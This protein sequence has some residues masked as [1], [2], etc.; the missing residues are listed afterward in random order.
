MLIA[1][2]DAFRRCPGDTFETH[3]HPAVF[4]D[5]ATSPSVRV[6]GDGPTRTRGLTCMLWC[7]IRGWFATVVR[8]GWPVCRDTSSPQLP[9][10][11]AHSYF[12]TRS[13][14]QRVTA[15]G[16]PVVHASLLRADSFIRPT[17][18]AQACGPSTDVSGLAN[19]D[20]SRR[21]RTTP[22]LGT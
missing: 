19:N 9:V 17:C 14:G 2:G 3:G 1:L 4:L 20:E 16:R 13:G 8:P 18:P 7:S 5:Q 6:W 22:P 12:T 21:R 15:H 11:R 10:L